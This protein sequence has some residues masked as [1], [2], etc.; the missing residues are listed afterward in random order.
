MKYTSAV[1][2]LHRTSG[3][4]AICNS[5]V[6]RQVTLKMYYVS[7]RWRCFKLRCAMPFWLDREYRR[8]H[9]WAIGP[10]GSNIVF[11]F[12]I[13][14]SYWPIACVYSTI[15]LTY[16]MR[17]LYDPIGLLHALDRNTTYAFGK[18]RWYNSARL[19]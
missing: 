12:T 15:L 4:Y 19:R 13:L 1:L 17:L 14:L 5:R 9:V 7:Y 8:L 18:L 11:Y 6:G 3:V 10:T 2:C 16:C